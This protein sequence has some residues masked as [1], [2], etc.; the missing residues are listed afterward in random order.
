MPD[1]GDPAPQFS[2]VDAITGQTH[3]LSDYAGQVVLLIFSGPSWCPPCQFEAPILVDLWNEFSQ[4][5]TTPKVQF[6]MV[7][8]FG[9]ETP[10]NF[11]TAVENFGI[12]FPA[13]LN[14]NQTITNLYGVT[15]VPQLFVINTKQ[16]ICNTHGGASPPA[17]ALRD[18]IYNMLIG[19]GASEPQ[20]WKLD[21]T[22]WAAVMTILFGV[23]QGGGGLGYTPGGKPI[24]IDPSGPL[25]RL[26]AEKKDVL[27]QLAISELAK[28][29]KDYRTAN[30][31]ATMALRGAE[32]S[33]KRAVELNALQPREMTRIST[34][35]TN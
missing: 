7:S 12:T 25:M 4:S 33:M 35:P 32:T 13:L 23:T 8:C 24:P 9:N 16:I 20:S 5:H 19:C 30:G 34:K 14:P 26:S 22:K 3:S 27:L 17:D 10:Q 1:V 2:A 6:L 21:I 15:G 31:I 28:G 18:H 29:V 11:K